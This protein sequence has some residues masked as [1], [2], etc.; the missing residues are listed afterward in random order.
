MDTRSLEHP[1][2]QKVSTG[3]GQ[4]QFDPY[5]DG[6]FSEYEIKGTGTLIECSKQENWTN[7][8]CV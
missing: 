4:D 7:P 5:P 3:T 6:E 1:T 2:L 8:D